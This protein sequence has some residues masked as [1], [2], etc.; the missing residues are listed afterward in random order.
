MLEGIA[1]VSCNS[2]W[3]GVC[4]HKLQPTMA[5]SDWLKTHSHIR[6]NDNQLNLDFKCFQFL[7]LVW[8]GLIHYSA[9][10]AAKAM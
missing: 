2:L 7:G 10:L 3:I 8:F 6:K 1:T 4:V 5:A 9:F